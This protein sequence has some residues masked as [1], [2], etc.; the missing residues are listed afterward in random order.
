MATNR[1]G[2]LWLWL[3]AA[4]VLLAALIVVLLPFMAGGISREQ[5]DQIRYGMTIDE[6]EAILGPAGWKDA[7]PNRISENGEVKAS[8]FEQWQSGR[9]FVIVALTDKGVYDRRYKKLT[10]RDAI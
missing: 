10:C 6:V 1:K 9:D 3:N 2:R 8:T 5:A 7:Y 4:V